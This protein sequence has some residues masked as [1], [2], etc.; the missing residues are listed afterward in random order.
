[1]AGACPL[2]IRFCWRV[3]SRASH[4]NVM[5]RI[6]DAAERVKL[7]V[8]RTLPPVESSPDTPMFEHL[9]RAV[10]LMD[11]EGTA[12]PYM[13]PG[14]T[15]AAPYAK[16]GIVH[17]GFSPVVFPSEPKVSFSELYHGDNERIP[18]DGFYAALDYWYYLL[19]DLGGRRAR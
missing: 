17:Y 4:N 1:M 10:R 7:E 5:P 3:S 16:L 12:I 15:D 6:P 9:A 11:P 18:V 19:R 2:L 14:F 8:M 13:I